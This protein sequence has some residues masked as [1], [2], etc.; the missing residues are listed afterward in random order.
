MRFPGQFPELSEARR[1]RSLDRTLARNPAAPE[2][3]VF[4]YG[5]LIWDPGFR[6]VEVAAAILPD[7]HR[8]FCVW[9][10]LARGTPARPGLAAGLRRD[11]VATPGAGCKGLLYRLDPATLA[12]DLVALWRREMS[13]GIYLPRWVRVETAAGQA[14]ALAFVVE[15][16]HPQFAADLPLAERARIIAGAAGKL[17]SARD[18]LAKLVGHLAR[19]DIADADLSILLS[20]VDQ[21]PFRRD[22]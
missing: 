5:S 21:A 8:S 20:R 7:Y 6:F 3:R 9:T 10:V 1:R 4:A 12:R 22:T 13:T 19:H 15:P 14:D 11:P 17:G 16:R 2:F 18:Y